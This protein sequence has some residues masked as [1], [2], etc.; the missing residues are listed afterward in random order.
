MKTKNIWSIVLLMVIVLSACDDRFEEINTNPNAVTDI[1]PEYLFANAVQQTIRGTPNS[2]INFPFG[3]QYGHIYV[4]QN[5]ARFIDHYYDHFTSAEYKYLFEAFYFGPIR[6]IQEVI[7][8]T[9]PGGEKENEVRHAMAQVISMFNFARLADSYGNVPY[10]EGGYGQEGVLYPEYDNVEFVYTDMMENLK[11]IVELLKTAD[12]E[13]GFPGADP[14]YDNDLSLWVSFANSVRL[15]LAM[16]ARFVNSSLANEIITECLGQPLIEQNDQNAWNENFDSD[17]GEFQNPI[18]G[19]YGYWQWKMSEKFVETLKSIGDPRLALFIKPNNDGEY[20]G[21]PNGLSDLSFP[22]WDWDN[23]SD[24]GEIL[25]G[26]AAPIYIM[27]AAEIWF[28]RAEAALFNLTSG[29]ANQL[30]RT[31]IQKTFEQ[32]GIQQGDIDSY[33]ADS[34]YANL[35]GTQEEQFEQICTHIWIAYMPNAHEG[36]TNIRR[37]GY[38]VIEQRTEPVYS[39]GVTDGVLPT[40]LRYPSSEVNINN[41]NYLKA[42]EQQGPDLITTPI[43]WD[44]RD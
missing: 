11:S 5:N 15:R 33:L 19:Q 34:A 14:L 2:N 31:G 16:R 9:Q 44:I 43:W 20:V 12:P 28:L 38:P 25:V 8:V 40:R 39:V 18:F 10:V 3:T 41:E 30:Y 21:I 36:W 42:I 27:C 13:M 26:K 35:S 6:H 37:T 24:P 29:D 32:W 4:G 17:V 23:T 22:L 7:R 1:D